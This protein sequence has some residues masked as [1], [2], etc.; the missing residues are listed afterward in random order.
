MIPRSLGPWCAGAALVLGLSTASPAGP[1]ESDGIRW[2]PG[3]GLTAP[4]GLW[5]AGDLTVDGDLLEHEPAS[6]ELAD[7]SLLARWEAS[8]RLSFF[9]ELRLDDVVEFVNGEGAN[10]GDWNLTLERLYVE[11]LLTPTLTLRLGEV[12]TPFGLW[13]VV[14]R[15][16]LTWTVERPAITESVFPQHA[17]G[18]SLLYQATWQ[19]WS[20]D[21]TTYGPAQD[22][23]SSRGPD[24]DE[25]PEDGLMFG[26]RVAAGHAVGPA[27][28]AVG[29]NALGFHP[30][31]WPGWSTVTGADLDL[32]LAAHHV[33][34]EFIFRISP[35][36]RLTRQ[37]LYLQDVIPLTPIVP[38]VRDLYGVLRFEQVQ[39]GH[40]PTGV[41]GLVGLWWRPIPLL[42]LRADY[43]FTNRTLN[44]F[45]PGFR[46]AVSIMF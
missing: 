39:Q 2:N 14:R 20:V 44:H 37:G 6:A 36:G 28:M 45:E 34:G 10:S 24:E 1:V 8:D 33:T 29:L 41:G 23:L 22:K 43:F 25:L 30:A 46:S 32:T 5:L 16:P 19:G 31:G 35:N 40:G 17:T 13:N 9:G 18:L 15:A 27:F 38:V 11:A 42:V 7:V 4:R 12:Y 3:H 26:G 21:A